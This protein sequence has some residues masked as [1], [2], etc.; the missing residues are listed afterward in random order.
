MSTPAR[1]RTIGLQTLLVALSALAVV[2]VLGFALTL[3]YL[4]WDS[5]Q[6]EARR[7]LQQTAGS[8]AIAIDR[9]IAGSLRELQRIAEHPSLATDRL[10]DF[11][12]Y[13]GGLVAA[14]DH[15]SNLLVI[16]REGR[17]LVDAS[18]P[19]GTPVPPRDLPHVRA[20][21]ESGRPQL[22]DV[23]ATHGSGT[24]AVAVAVPVLR[25]DGVRWVLSARLDAEVLSQLLAGQ[26]QRAGAIAAVLD[27]SRFIVARSRDSA[28]FFAQPATADLRAAVDASPARG[29][30]RL[31]TLDGQPVLAAWQ[32]LPSGW[33]LTLG[34]T[35]EAYDPALRRSIA[36]LLAFGL[37]VLGLGAALSLLL[38]RRI[39]GAIEACASDARM[40][41]SGELV[42]E[43]PSR[44]TQVAALFRS[45]AE[46]GR[47]QREQSR[48][49]DLALDALRRS[50]R[51]V[52]TALDSTGAGAFDW[53]PRSDEVTWTD[54]ARELLGIP[55]D[56]A[57]FEAFFRAVHPDDR[58][59]VRTVF[60]EALAGAGDGRIRTHF[61]VPGP[62]GAL[63]W[64][65]AGAQIEFHGFASARHAVRLVG[66]VIDQTERQRQVEALHE[67]DRRKDEFLA[68]L[69]HELRN[70][71]APMRNAIALFERTLPAAGPQRE[72]LRM[73]DRQMRHLTRLVDDLLDV[74]RITQGKIELR[75]EP[76]EIE[77]AVR[78]ALESIRPTIDGRGHR[79]SL[80]MPERSPVVMGDP[81]RLVQVIENLLSN[82]SK[83]T[84]PGGSI[85][86]EVESADGEVTLR[87]RDDG[88]GIA[89]EQLGR[90]F[91]L[92]AQVDATLDRSQGGLGIGLSLV[93]RLVE[94]HGGSVAA[95]SDGP[96]R[97][98]CFV[99]RLPEVREAVAA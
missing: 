81:L 32:R 56:G 16:D 5:G 62:D 21:F 10:G 58:P 27:R 59:R 74:S 76:V 71:L 82:A 93:K 98:A 46:A 7:E 45:L 75:R 85:S 92:F 39:S 2:P 8:L 57:G 65:D 86:V 88:I 12:R 20:A 67:A 50:E 13:V 72:A 43:R 91:E 66:V 9:E 69:A 79:L 17:P 18:V 87:V 95:L 90:V 14:D 40:L 96:G 19:Y 25:D 28:R 11:H 60:A 4:L 41:A 47:L 38:G 36:T 84:D 24:P 15:W 3:L 94:M 61:R 80:A 1:P 33:T 26:L 23:Y 73:S 52:Q 54:R 35:L 51:R 49:R 78:Q 22:S 29:S 99:V 77:T 53:D 37:G 55:R 64:L 97:G 6:D 63:R 31:V 44:I 42:A 68:M 48:A 30:A 34:V 89:R 83:Y 70:P